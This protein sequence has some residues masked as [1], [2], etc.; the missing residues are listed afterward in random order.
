MEDHGW[1]VWCQE[2]KEGEIGKSVIEV[3]GKERDE[4][5]KK[6]EMRE[7]VMEVMGKERDE[8]RRKKK[9]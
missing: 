3:I 8:K 4:E 6:G 5:K 1:K 9:K 2:G 7:S